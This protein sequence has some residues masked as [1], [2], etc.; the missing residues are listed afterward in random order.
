MFPWNFRLKPWVILIGKH[1]SIVFTSSAVEVGDLRSPGPPLRQPY[2]GAP[3]PEEEKRMD[4]ES[5]PFGG[6]SS[7]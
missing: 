4:Q 5:E 6:S 2:P 7:A 3:Y 1:P